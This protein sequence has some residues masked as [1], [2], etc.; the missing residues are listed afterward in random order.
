MYFQGEFFRGYF[1]N[2]NVTESA[3]EPGHFTYT[4]NFTVTRRSGKRSNFMPW[5]RNPLEYDG[6]T[7]MSQKVTEAKG[8]W[9]G[10]ERLSFL[11]SEET[12]KGDPGVYADDLEEEA[13]KIRSFFEQ[14]ERD[15][16]NQLNSTPDEGQLIEDL[17]SNNVPIKRGSYRD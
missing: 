16:I 3:Q 13:N 15:K 5:H 8:S 14:A 17:D 11:P 12:W 10:V 9:P 6:E 7:V 4:M 2:F 1:T